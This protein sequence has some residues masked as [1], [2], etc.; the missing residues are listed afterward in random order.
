MKRRIFATL[1]LPPPCFAS[2]KL[3]LLLTLVIFTFFVSLKTSSSE[4]ASVAT[5]TSRTTRREW[6][7]TTR[8]GEQLGGSTSKYDIGKGG[9]IVAS[10][11]GLLSLV[12]C[13]HTASCMR[14]S[15]LPGLDESAWV[16]LLG[17]DAGNTGRRI[18]D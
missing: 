11:T 3:F 4:Y 12:V 10:R 15:R 6:Q 14:T 18:V 9:N 16:E 17:P 8:Q 1:A 5:G 7:R 13:V 2:S